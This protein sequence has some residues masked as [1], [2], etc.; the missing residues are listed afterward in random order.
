MAAGGALALVLALVSVAGPAAAAAVPIDLYAVAGSTTLPAGGQA[1]TVW[2]YNTTGAAAT[3]PGGPTLV[4][5]VG[6]TVQI[7]LHNQLTEATALLVQGQAMVPDRVGAAPAGTSVYSFTA[8]RPGTYLY[9]A[10]LLA[11]AQHQVAMGLY[12]ALVVRPPTAGRAYD[13]ASTA[14]DDEAVLVLSEIDPALNNAPS[15]A[16][17]D[18]RKYN[19]RY[20][21]VNGKAY[22]DT[23]P[24]TTAVGRTTLLRYVNAGSQYHSM[25]VLGAHQSVVALDGSPLN[26][27]RQ[28]VA[29]TFGPGQTAD[30]LVTPTA[31][32]TDR[33]LVVHDGSL[34][35]HNSNTAGIGG[36]LTLL[37]VTGTGGGDDA[38]PATSAVQSAADVTATIS[39]AGTGGAAI[40][41]A[42]Y[43]VD[44]VASGTGT[45]MSPVDGTFDSATEDVVSAGAPALV[46]QH[47]LYARGQDA[48]GNWGPFSSVLISAGDSAGPTTSAQ[49]LTPDATNGT[50]AVIVSATADDTAS[51][52]GDIAAAEL[53]V[54]AVGTNGTG[55][56]LTVGTASSVSSIDGTIAAAIV[57]ALAEG[58]HVVSIHARDAAGNWGD[59]ATANL[60]V[61][62]TGPTTTSPVTVA[63]TPNNGTLPF[64]SG[65]AAVRVTTTVTDPA[66]GG[67]NTPVARAEGFIDAVGATGTGFVVN[68]ADGGYSSASEGVY[69]DIPL[70]TVAALANGSHTISVHGRDAAGNWGPF[71]TGTLV[72]DK[73]RPVISAL[74]ATPNPTLGATT[75]T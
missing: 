40:Q 44:T 19:P 17:F 26:L 50:A 47:V 12:G 58:S 3:A 75:I 28:Y 24:I 43:Y 74:T 16:G 11:N 38:G 5:N 29:E 42:E 57:N 63:V 13:S 56:P 60:T 18:M 32:T 68:A 39:D 73:V 41:A 14:F 35:L 36:M 52:G 72:V 46:G 15:P 51:G 31:S 65:I 23:A 66:S 54:D 21:L 8:S 9:E 30:A 45:A 61:D 6:D 49:T 10:G 22:P 59:L 25:S 69:A 1:V 64:N 70:A 37:D 20:F 67:V 2:G 27:A 33:M 4:V 62:K 53:F 48:L 55:A 71:A 7:T 34:L